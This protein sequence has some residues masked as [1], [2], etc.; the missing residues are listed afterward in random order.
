M[1]TRGDAVQP[2]KLC[3]DVPDLDAHVHGAPLD[4]RVAEERPAR[5]EQA[6]PVLVSL[7]RLLGCGRLWLLSKRRGEHERACAEDGGCAW[8]DGGLLLLLLFC[9]KRQ[10]FSQSDQKNKQPKR[11]LRFCH[12][13]PYAL[14]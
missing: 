3:A 9:A 14:S 8:H 12:S 10:R 4:K 6:V 13:P 11:L 7:E 5:D 2:N 1:R